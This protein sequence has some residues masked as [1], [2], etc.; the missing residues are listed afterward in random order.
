ML[1]LD[2]DLSDLQT[3]NSSQGNQNRSTDRHKADSGNDY[4]AGKKYIQE[5][6]GN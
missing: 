3:G 5:S 1:I 6:E 2:I 4:V